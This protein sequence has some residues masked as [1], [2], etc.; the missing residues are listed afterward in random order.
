MAE[1]Y[2]YDHKC[3]DFT[4]FGLVGALT[5]I[6][7]I[8]EE[9][10][11][12]MS[13]ITLEH[14]MD[15]YEKYKA[16]Q[17]NRL[18]MVEVPV[19]TTPEINDGEIVT[20]IFAYKVQSA[21]RATRTLY[22]T[23]SGNTKILVLPVGTPVS[24]V[25]KPTTGRLKVKTIYGNGWLPRNALGS[26]IT[27]IEIPS[28]PSGI[29]SVQPAWKVKPQVFRIYNVKK[30][31]DSVTVCARH[32]T[33]DLMHNLTTYKSALEVSCKTALQGIMDGC[34]NKDH[35]FEAFTNIGN[36]RAG[37]EWLRINP[38]NALLVPDTGLGKLFGAHLVRDNWEIY[39]LDDPGMDRGVTIEYS[40]NMLGIE[41]IEDTDE[42]ATRII[43][44]GETK[45]GKPLLLTDK[46]D[47]ENWIDSE[48]RIEVDGL[49][50]PLIAMYPL[51]YVK[52]HMCENCKVG[53]GGLSTKAQ[54][55]ARMREQVEALYK[56]DI[57]LPKI[58]MS[59]DFINIGDTEEYRQYKDL[60]RLFLF[61]FVTI[62]H[63]RHGIS[64]KAK[65][66]RIQ[67]DCLLERMESMEIGNKI[68]QLGSTGGSIADIQGAINKY[69]QGGVDEINKSGTLSTAETDTGGRWIDNKPIYTRILAFKD[70]ASGQMHSLPLGD[71]IETAWIDPSAS[72]CVNSSG[73]V[74]PIGYTGASGTRAFVADCQRETGNVR[75]GSFTG[76]TADIYVKFC[77]TKA[78]DEPIEEAV[79]H[80]A[81]MDSEGKLFI[82]ADGAGFM[83]EVY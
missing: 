2:V 51:V 20:T 19:R 60:E 71:G 48:R 12:G 45:D 7:C 30:G 24:V 3:E 43:P 81:F 70:V 66:V 1:I 65:I 47:G 38:V 34:V 36:T 31:I 42:I 4:N 21:A 67:W 22:K 80:A 58:S 78:A 46:A 82:D 35:G 39:M 32:I 72:F 69:F 15:E 83:T 37:L 55:R 54:A 40:K 41:Y 59:V 6:S 18:L 63:K 28:V 14:P 5:P 50:V 64:V 57:D 8:F 26:E 49:M 9:E 53:S 10:A 13:E 73:Y 23:Q 79:S 27:E 11:D 33:Y 75:A 61:D 29:E 56:N 25:K 77:Y 68:E 62:R 74:Y 76:S 52:E 17:Y 16:L 44:V